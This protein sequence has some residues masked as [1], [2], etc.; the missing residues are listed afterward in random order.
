MFDSSTV[1]QGPV[2]QRTGLMPSKHLT[3]V[4]FPPGPPIF[5]LVVQCI[6]RRFPKSVM[7][8]GFPP[9]LPSCRKYQPIEV[10]ML[11]VK[12]FIL[13][14]YSNIMEYAIHRWVLHGWLWS[15]HVKHHRDENKNVFFVRDFLGVGT[16]L[17]LIGVSSVLFSFWGWLP[18]FVLSFYYFVLLEG[19]HWFIHELRISRH[20]MQHHADLKDGNYNVWI[21]LGDWLFGT[22]I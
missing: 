12:I 20:H 5:R 21:P 14:A 18:L 17:G 11:L 16:A 1:C 15:R 13:L 3:R 7:R 19:A 6:E 22:K 10:V 4:G 2:V 8:V 9:S